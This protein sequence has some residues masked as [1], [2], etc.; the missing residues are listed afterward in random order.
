MTPQTID[1]VL[2]ELDLIIQRAR[3]A[4]SRL[5]FFATLYRNVTF[6]V[7][8]GIAAGAFEDGPRMEQLD[9]AFA[10]RY[11]TALESF[12]NKQPL[13]KCWRVAFQ[14]ADNW[15]PIIL[16]HLLIGMNAHINF[17][18]GL[19]AQNVAPGDKLPALKDDFN[20]INEI[21]GSMI[22]K[23]RSNIEELSP[24]I[25]L[26]DRYSSQSEDRLVNFS[27]DKARTSAWLVANMINATPTSVLGREL[28]IL[29][30]GVANLGSLIGSPR[31]LLINLGLRVI[32]V[33]ESSDVPHIMDVLAQM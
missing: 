5:G 23:V 7:K 11:I 25:K 3:T 6:R 31:E 28:E 21:L 1:E 29:D 4:Q 17:D 19:A 9:V 18:L 26:L 30:D 15:F 12:Q 22:L 14:A 13:S 20:K 10:T 2:A 16:Q 33:R 8:E 24:W 27:L 32:R